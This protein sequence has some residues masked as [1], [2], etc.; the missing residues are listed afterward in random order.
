MRSEDE[1]GSGRTTNVNAGADKNRDYWRGAEHIN[2]T[3]CD[4]KIHVT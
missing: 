3:L 4:I 1:K 2:H